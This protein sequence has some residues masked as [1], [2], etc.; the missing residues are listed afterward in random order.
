[1]ILM[2]A[3]GTT[4]EIEWYG[5]SDFDRNLY[6]GAKNIAAVDAVSIFANPKQTKELTI[7]KDEQNMEDETT[8]AT[9]YG[10]TRFVSIRINDIENTINIGLGRE[11][12]AG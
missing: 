9:W 2:T 6:I 1:M 7:F 4:V 12:A 3:T 11:E 5:R 8:L 10:F